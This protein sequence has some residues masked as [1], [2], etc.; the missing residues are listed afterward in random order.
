MSA[1]RSEMS[2]TREEFRNAP[3]RDPAELER[4]ADAARE[5]IRQTIDS[6]EQRFSPGQLV[7]RALHMWR[8]GDNEFA[9]NLSRTVKANPVP[10]VM[11]SVGLA[12][13]A[14][15]DKRPPPPPQAHSHSGG[16][17]GH[18]T[19]S[20][21]HS[22]RDALGSARE[23]ASHAAGSFSSQGARAREGF[24]RMQTEQPF[25]LGA[26][27]L[28][29]GAALG[30]AFPR[31]R[32]ED[33]M[34]GKYGDRAREA[35]KHT[36]EEAMGG[37]AQATDPSRDAGAGRDAGPGVAASRAPGSPTPGTPYSR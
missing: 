3:T 21:M 34:I 36:G 9:S 16:G 11:S 7:D 14:M 8:S 19:S 27:A 20:A 25:L 30:G 2:N 17:V 28:A 1:T 22:T 35:A 24:T 13:L 29:L 33:E 18:A 10:V 15:A 31:S 37:S 32:A 4:E 23:R 26:M 5:S 6:L 12:W